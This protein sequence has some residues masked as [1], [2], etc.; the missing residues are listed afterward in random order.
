M[1]TFSILLAADLNIDERK[2]ISSNYLSDAKDIFNFTNLLVQKT[3]YF[4]S[5]DGILIDL[6][7]TNT[8]RS[9]LKPQNFEISLSGCHVIINS[10]LVF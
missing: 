2:P 10:L 1:K 7:L 5:Q 3:T 9:F 6:M 8:L 4:K